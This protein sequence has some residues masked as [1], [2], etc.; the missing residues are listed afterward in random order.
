MVH[1]ELGRNTGTIACR[2]LEQIESYQPDYYAY[3]YDA[4]VSPLKNI[5]EGMNWDLNLIRGKETP[6]LENYLV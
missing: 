2:D 4:V 6:I 5:F 3:A 1:K